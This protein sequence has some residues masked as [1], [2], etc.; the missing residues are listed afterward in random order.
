M[1]YSQEMLDL[2][3]TEKV[4]RRFWSKVDKTNV[5]GCWKWQACKNPLGYGKFSMRG[6]NYEYFTYQAHILSLWSHINE[7]PRNRFTCHKCDQPSCVNPN[8]L[9][10]GTAKEN[11]QDA[12]IKGRLFNI[13]TV[14]HCKITETQALEILKIRRDTGKGAKLI[15]KIF[16]DVGV[17]L[18]KD[19]I[20]NK[21]WKHLPR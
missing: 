8:H 2:F 6:S 14:K 11:S 4:Q 10:Y 17:Y 9:W 5:K 20:S 16:P 15:H 19:L 21:T 18:I 7:E 12:Y 1:K 3:N 13:A